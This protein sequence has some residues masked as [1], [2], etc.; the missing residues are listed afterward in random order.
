MCACVFAWVRLIM[1]TYM[2]DPSFLGNVI[3]PT[4]TTSVEPLTD[5]DKNIGFRL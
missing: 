3:D 2:Y 4:D 1:S 5:N